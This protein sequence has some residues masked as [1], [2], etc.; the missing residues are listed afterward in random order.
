MKD[1][2]DEIGTPTDEELK[3]PAEFVA[4]PE[5]SEVGRGLVYNCKGKH[6]ACINKYSYFACRDNLKWAKE[7]KKV[8]ECYTKDVYRNEK[9]CRIIQTH[10]INTN[11]KTDFC[12]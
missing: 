9:D 6:W 11:L 7:N 2:V 3:G 5:Y 1:I 8:L 12:K 4:A 10:Y